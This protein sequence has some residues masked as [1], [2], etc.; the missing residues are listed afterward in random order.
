[1]HTL[2]L[3]DLMAARSHARDVTEAPRALCIRWAWIGMHVGH[4]LALDTPT[5]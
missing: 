4:A 2:K 5:Q 3:T 1:M